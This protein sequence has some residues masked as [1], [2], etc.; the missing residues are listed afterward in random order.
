MQT[1]TGP[2]MYDTQ[3]R[4][5]ARGSEREGERVDQNGERG[6]YFVLHARERSTSKKEPKNGWKQKRKQR[7]EIIHKQGTMWGTKGDKKQKAM[8][9]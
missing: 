9:T 2:I 4:R 7:P 5:E 1:C 3:R 6:S 8:D